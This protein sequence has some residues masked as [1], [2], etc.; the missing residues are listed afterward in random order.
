MAMFGGQRSTEG[1]EPLA[2]TFSYQPVLEI[3]A[4]GQWVLARREVKKSLFFLGVL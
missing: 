3:L 4:Q 2:S 1:L